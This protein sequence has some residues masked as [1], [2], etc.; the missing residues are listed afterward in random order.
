MRERGM[1]C[2]PADAMFAKA[3]AI[4]DELSNEVAHIEG[5]NRA[6]KNRESE[7]E[8]LLYGLT[9]GGSEFLGDPEACAAFAAGQGK[10]VVEA[11]RKRNEAEARVRE[12]EAQVAADAKVVE[13]ASEY[14]KAETLFDEAFANDVPTELYWKRPVRQIDVYLKTRALDAALAAR[15]AAPEAER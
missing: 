10:R 12:L 3:Y 11:I 14:R 5:D 8:A 9:P 4:I 13:A 6:L 7:L 1:Y 2:T 15:K